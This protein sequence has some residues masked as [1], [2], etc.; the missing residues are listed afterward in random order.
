MMILDITLFI[1]KKTGKKVKDYENVR[2]FHKVFELPFIP[3]NKMK[4]VLPAVNPSNI[5]TLKRCAYNTATGKFQGIVDVDVT[6]EWL[7]SEGNAYFA[8]LAA[9]GWLKG[10][11]GI[12]A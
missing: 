1:N 2:V 4:L 9:A 3:Q 5:Q 8:A 12:F 7:R 10:Y 6:A 11:G